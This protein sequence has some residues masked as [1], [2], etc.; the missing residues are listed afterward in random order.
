MA[1]EK[2]FDPTPA[3]LARAKREGDVPRSRDISAVAAFACAALAAFAVLPALESAA[4]HAVQDAGGGSARPGPYVSM[5]GGVALVLFAAAASGVAASLLQSGGLAFR[6]PSPN[7]KRLDP[8]AGLGRTFGR[9][10]A[11]AAAKALVVAAAVAGAVVPAAAP[12]FVVTGAGAGPPGIAA[13]VAHALEAA[14][15]GATAVAAA[16]AAGD[17]LVERVKWRRRLRMSFDEVKRERKSSEGDPLVRGRRRLAHRSLARGSIERVKD[18]AFVVANPTHVAVA[19]AYAPPAVA[20][21]R[22]LVRAADDAAH[23][24]RERARTL[25]IPVVEDVALARALFARTDVD[26]PI[27]RDTYG[28]VAAIVAALLHAERR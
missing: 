2:P 11:L 13:A 19:L 18:A 12:A 25:G 17:V 7:L 22:V 27:P 20:V 16:F 24:V 3:R 8:F 23:A 9:D 10:A 21:P 4:R 26:D 1:E 14:F 15:A 28:A 6:L 5:A